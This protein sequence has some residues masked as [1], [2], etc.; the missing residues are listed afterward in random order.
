MHSGPE[1]VTYRRTK[2]QRAARGSA[3][4]G[5]TRAVSPYPSAPW[6]LGSAATLTTLSVY[7]VAISCRKP[8][9]TREALP[10]A[11]RWRD[12]SWL[13]IHARIA[14]TA[15]AH[16]LLWV[17]RGEAELKTR[18]RYVAGMASTVDALFASVGVTRLVVVPW[19]A[20]IPSEAPGVFPQRWLPAWPI[21]MTCWSDSS[22]RRDP[23]SFS[24]GSVRHPKCWPRDLPR[25]GCPMNQPSTSAWPAPH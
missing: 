22:W 23:S 20:R 14:R 3:L 13:T 25:C 2:F 11:W 15:F 24:T 21:S 16:H 9:R 4:A 7:A 8:W 5:R 10:A 6:N 12:D 19:R 17:V 1:S 18:A